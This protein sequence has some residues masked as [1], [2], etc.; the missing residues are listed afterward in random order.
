MHRYIFTLIL[1]FLAGV[2]ATVG[3][4]DFALKTNGLYWLTG[5]PNLGAE[6]ALSRKVTAEISAAYNPWAI[7]KNK[8]LHFILLQPEAK[9]WFCEKFEGHFIGVHL[10][11]AQ[12]YS[13]LAA[14]RRDGYLAGAGISY[15]Y[16]WILSPHFNIEAE[17]GIC[18]ARMWY[19]ES[20][21]IPCIKN[22]IRKHADYYGPTKAAVSFVY[23]F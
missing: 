12:F 13:T 23:I 10:H 3:A 7:T 17:I 11:G 9:Y 18:Y 19:K 15:G 4:Q 6:V 2:S 22:Q 21:C 8:K 16:D 5:T 20:D 14:K 1:L